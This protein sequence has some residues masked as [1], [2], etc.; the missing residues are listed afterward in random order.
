MARNLAGRTIAITGA[1]SGIGA[2][3]AV[4][5]AR[6]G[7]RVG[8]L[9]R[10]EER[11]RD[12]AAEVDRVGGEAIVHAADV[13]DPASVR[14]LVTE[15]TRRWHRLDVVMANAGFGIS[16]RVADT[17]PDEAREIFE[18]N[19]LG[20]V[21]AIQAAWPIFEVQ[22]SGHVVIVSSGVA[23]HGMP[24]NALYSATKAAQMNLAEGLRIEAEPVGIEVSV[25][26]P[27]GTDT[28]FREARRDHLGDPRPALGGKAGGPR[29]TVD[30]VADAIVACLESPT[31][32]VYPYRPTRL[33]PFLEAVSPKLAAKALRYPDYYRRQ[34]KGSP[35][36]GP[37]G[38]GDRS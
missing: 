30:E 21:W 32:E 19:V 35:A 28:E 15:M 18:V 4:A 6:S 16:A 8:L 38:E 14:G 17:P 37:G 34:V 33:L 29:Q 25:V 26:Y 11:L 3:T 27:I 13:R 7:M 5:C 31:F 36:T 22:R 1:S 12:V 9:A 20:T 2:A 10:R 23:K 24:A